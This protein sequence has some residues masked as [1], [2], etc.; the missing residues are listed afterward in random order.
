MSRAVRPGLT[1]TRSFI[2]VLAYC[3]SSLNI[4]ALSSPSVPANL[5]LNRNIDGNKLEMLKRKT[6]Y[7]KNPTTDTR[8]WL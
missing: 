4:S 3:L 2:T 7:Q 6:M 1:F 5:F 8:T